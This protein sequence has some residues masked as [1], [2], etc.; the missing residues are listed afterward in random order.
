M[1]PSPGLVQS[2]MVEFIP[3]FLVIM[4]TIQNVQQNFVW[5]KRHFANFT[6]WSDEVNFK[7]NGTVNRHNCVYRATENPRLT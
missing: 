6:V 2:T 5:R 3:L 4:R 7:L 1:F